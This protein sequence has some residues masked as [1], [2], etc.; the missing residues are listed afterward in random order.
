M[1]SVESVIEFSKRLLLEPFSLVDVPLAV[2]SRLASTLLIGFFLEFMQRASAQVVSVI[3]PV[4]T[5]LGYE[6]VGAE[7]GQ[8][9]NGVTLRVYIDKPEGIL[10][11]DCAV[12]NRQ[13]NAVLDVEDTIKS[14]YLLE[15]SSPGVDRPLFTEAHFAAQ[16]GE[17]VRVRM[18]EAVSGRRNFKGKLIHVEGG[19]AIIEVD[20]I[21]YEIPVRDVEQA[22]VKG[23]LP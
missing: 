20:G 23:R 4:V 5:G 13:L 6:L 11:E 1:E 15:V 2:V 8:A 17:Q 3:E 9:E 21:D 14:A 16:K 10:M 12:V 18:G 7:F 22:H 19:I